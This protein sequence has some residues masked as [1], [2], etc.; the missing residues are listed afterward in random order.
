MNET[1]IFFA[2]SQRHILLVVTKSD[3]K[4]ACGNIRKYQ[5][6]TNITNGTHITLWLATAGLYGMN[7]SNNREGEVIETFGEN[8]LF[9]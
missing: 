3:H 4:R 1:H 8:S 5:K 9:Q 2:L 7:G 6:M